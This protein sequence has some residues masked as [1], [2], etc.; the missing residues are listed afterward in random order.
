M[1][2]TPTNSKRESLPDL[3]SETRLDFAVLVEEKVTPD[4]VIEMGTQRT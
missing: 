4:P 1:L 2:G 3:L